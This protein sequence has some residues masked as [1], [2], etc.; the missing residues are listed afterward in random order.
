MKT[1]PTSV[2]GMADR[3]EHDKKLDPGRKPAEMLKFI[4]VKPG[5]HVADLGAGS[6]YT[7]EL[8][9]RSVGPT[10]KVIAQDSP[11]WD[12]PDLKKLWVDRLAR[13]GLANT[14]HVMQAW[15]T[16]LPADAKDLDAVVFN[17]AYHDVIGEKAD[18]K[19]LDAAVF[20]ALK[21]HGTFIVIDNTTKDGAG[22]TEVEHLHRIEEKTVRADLEAAGFKFVSDASFLRN[23]DDT[24][25]WNADPDADKRTHTQDRFVL[26]FE[27][28]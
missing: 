6:G 26:K 13:P 7:T 22:A 10:G 17:C 9:A 20:A 18:V 8:L 23:P 11:S 4:D 12:G 5:M 2:V 21:P 24:R 15:E 25:D 27:K 19:K 3:T 16:P 28:P 14:T 1:D